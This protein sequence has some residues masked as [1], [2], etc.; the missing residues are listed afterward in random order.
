M[1]YNSREGGYLGEI[2][3][4]DELIQEHIELNA[5]PFEVIEDIVNSIEGYCLGS[6]GLV[7]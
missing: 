4:P 6:T 5:E 3:T 2:Y 7:L 1:S